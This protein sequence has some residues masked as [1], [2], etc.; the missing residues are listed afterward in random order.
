M[1]KKI[2]ITGG[3]GFLGSHL[4]KRCHNAGHDVICLDDLSTGSKSFIKDL[5]PLERFTFLNRDISAPLDQDPDLDLDLN[6]IYNFACPASPKFYQKDPI[7]TIKTSV[8]GAFFVCE[9]AKK[10]GAKIF[11]ASTSEVY[12]D[13]KEHPQKESYFGNVNFF[14]KRSCYDEGKRIAETIFFEYQN[15]HG[16]EVNIARIFNT[17]GPNMHPSDGRVITNLIVQALKNEPLTIYGDGSQTRSFC[18]VT[19]LID[20]ATSLMEHKKFKGPVN[21]GNPNEISILDL[22]KKIKSLTNASSTITCLKLPEDDPKIRRPDI[23]LAKEHLSFSPKVS[24]DEGLNRTI[25]YLEKHLEN[26]F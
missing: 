19:D 4:C 8:M 3:A 10:T 7:K 22:A 13:P 2:L 16:V 24:L 21:L 1:K 18:F 6:E 20:A 12:G 17:Y 25:S 26:E 23:A 9:L 15:I 14:G 5:L 11:Q